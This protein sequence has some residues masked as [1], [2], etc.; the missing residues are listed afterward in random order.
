MLSSLWD[1]T[2]KQ[3][4]AANYMLHNLCNKGHGRWYPVSVM[5]HI[6][7]PLLLIKKSSS[8]SGSSGCDHLSGLQYVLCHTFINKMC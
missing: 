8:C 3:S 4:L 1:G 5:V 6:K 7:E 2:C